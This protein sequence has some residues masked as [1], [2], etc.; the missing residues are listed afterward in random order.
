[1]G[2]FIAYLK[3]YLPAP[4]WMDGRKAGAG[5]YHK[6]GSQAAH[7]AGAG[8]GNTKAARAA[9]KQAAHAKSVETK[10]HNAADAKARAKD[11][12]CLRGGGGGGSGAAALS[13]RGQYDDGLAMTMRR[14]MVARISMRLTAARRRAWGMRKPHVPLTLISCH[15]KPPLASGGAA[16][17]PTL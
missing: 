8:G 2:N 16:S 11:L 5:G 9:A 4:V 7:V 15:A 13:R 10:K 6:K 14:V 12:G 3:K 17:L 1:M